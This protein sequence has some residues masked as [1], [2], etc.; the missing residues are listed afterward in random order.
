MATLQWFVRSCIVRSLRVSFVRFVYRAFVRLRFPHSSFNRISCVCFVYRA[1]VSCI[2]RFSYRSC[3]AFVRFACVY[4]KHNI[5]SFFYPYAKVIWPSVLKGYTLLFCFTHCQTFYIL[6]IN[7][8]SHVLWDIFL[9]WLN[10]R[11][12]I[13]S[14]N[15]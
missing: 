10:P 7:K 8:K 1:F 4:N 2:V 15:L 3:E 9:N 6:Q 11:I 12:Q 5:H 14:Y 13:Q